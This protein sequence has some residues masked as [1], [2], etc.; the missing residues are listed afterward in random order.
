MADNVP[1]NLGSGGATIGADEISTVHYQRVKLIHG[2]DGT[3]DGDA[4]KTNPFPVLPLGLPK[5]IK[6]DVTRP[7]DTA[8][9]AAADC[10]SD[11][12]SAPTSGGFTI[13]DAGRASGGSCIIPDV[14]VASSNDPATRLAGEIFIFDTSAT[15]VNDN[16]AFV[17][18]D[19]EIKTCVAVI[20]FS[21][22]DAGNNQ[23]AHISGL[24][25]LATCSGTANLRFLLSA[26]NAYTPAS[27]EV[28]SFAFKL[29][30]VD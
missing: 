22:F 28:L 23:F 14:C 24:N 25:I 4:A 27:A 17:V 11:S 15:N 19:T 30:Q 9:Y 20:P 5:T 3:N 26:R 12:T 1:L 29:F 6:I 21:L 8:V 18:S 2:V 13:T 7:A 10:I 16:A